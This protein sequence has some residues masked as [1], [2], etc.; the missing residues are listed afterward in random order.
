M[1]VW[2]VGRWFQSRP[3]AD[4]DDLVGVGNVAL[5]NA[6]RHYDPARGVKFNT[7]AVR[8]ILMACGRHLKDAPRVPGGGG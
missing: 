5:C 1:P 8:C 6:T 7:Y 2:A 4:R 3:A